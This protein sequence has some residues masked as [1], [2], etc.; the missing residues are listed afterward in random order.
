MSGVGLLGIFKHIVIVS[1]R[2]VME[3]GLDE[4]KGAD[5]ME[6]D[7]TGWGWLRP[8]LLPSTKDDGLVFI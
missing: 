6:V 7:M 2:S 8:R 1:S 4:V 3:V 5:V